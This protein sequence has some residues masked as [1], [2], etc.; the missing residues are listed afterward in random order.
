MAWI[1]LIVAGL[2]EMLGVTFIN[3]LHE[4]RNAASFF[5]L[6]IS[7]SAS[8]LF[9]ALAMK[10]LPMGVAYAVWTG[11]GTIG[12]ALLGMLFYGESKKASRLFCIGLVLAATI[13]LKLVS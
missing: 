10:S 5:L 4:K 2:F 7:F 1:S 12:A 11:I 8:F 13:G 6:V 3:Q 9:L